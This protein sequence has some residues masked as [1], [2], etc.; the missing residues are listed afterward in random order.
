MGGSQIARYGFINKNVK[1]YVGTVLWLWLWRWLCG[2][3]RPWRAI[4]SVT[5]WAHGLSTKGK[6]NHFGRIASHI[7]YV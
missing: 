3:R 1:S 7:C 5:F 6:Q 2:G 4:C